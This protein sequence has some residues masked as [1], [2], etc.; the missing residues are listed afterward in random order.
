M[1][2]DAHP[3]I[4]R[5]VIAGPRDRVFE[6]FTRADLLSRWFTPSADI[7][8]DIVDFRFVVGGSFRFRY[9]MPDG[10]RPVVGGV[11]ER[12]ARPSEIVLSWVWEAPDPLAGV[13]MRVCFRF[14]DHNGGTEVVITHLKLPSDMACTLH[15]DGWE[16]ALDSLELFM[17]REKAAI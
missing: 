1:S 17:A 7:G 10:R 4:V 9:G 16:R 15:E 8:L 2:D 14:D 6:A 11:Y 13:D 12:I 3:L 5:R